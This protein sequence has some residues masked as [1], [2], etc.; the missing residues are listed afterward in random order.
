MHVERRKGL[1][2]AYEAPAA[3]LRAKIASSIPRVTPPSP[4][5]SRL[6]SPTSRE[7]HSQTTGSI[8]SKASVDKQSNRD[9]AGRGKNHSLRICGQALPV[10]DPTPNQVRLTRVFGSAKACPTPSKCYHPSLQA[11]GF[12]EGDARL[13]ADLVAGAR[14]AGGAAGV[15]GLAVRRSGVRFSRAVPG[16]NCVQ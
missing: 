8:N 12:C 7:T 4:T 9:S 1:D 6:G 5:R 14:N 10:G 16:E 13:G 11:S 15:Q 2:W 3:R